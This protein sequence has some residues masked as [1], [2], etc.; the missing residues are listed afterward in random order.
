MPEQGFA[1]PLHR[2]A[3]GD[4]PR[5]FV[6]PVVSSDDGDLQEDL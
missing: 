1:L 6:G 4:I 3:L 2:S 5:V